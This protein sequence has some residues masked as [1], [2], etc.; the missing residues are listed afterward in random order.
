VIPAVACAVDGA[1]RQDL[2]AVR[3]IRRLSWPARCEVHLDDAEGRSLGLL[4]T[5]LTVRV[6]GDDEPLFTGTVTGANLVREPDGTTRTRLVGQDA[7]HAL[8]GRQTVR[9][10][11]R[12]DPAALVAAVTAGPVRREVDGPTFDRIVQH[13]HDD[14]DLVTETLGR[15]GL[16]VV[17]DGD[18]LRIV[19]LAGYGEPL[20]L[21]HG[22][23]LFQ[24][25]ASTSV[26]RATATE[27]LGWHPQ[28]AEALRGR[29]GDG[30]EPVLLLDE[31]GRDGD[32][33]RAVA[34]GTVDA[35]KAGAVVLD[36]VA[37]GDAR[38]TPGRR[39]LVRG[40][41]EALDTGYTLTAVTSIVDGDGYRSVLS[42]RPP[43]RPAARSATSLTLGTVTAVD[44]PDGCGRVRV[45]LPAYDALDAGWI[46]VVTPGAGAGRGL[47]V[48]PDT[49]DP[50]LVALPHEPTGDAVVL[51]SLFGANRAEDSGTKRWALRTAGGQKIVVDD[52]HDSIRLESRNGG[53]VELA[54]DRLRIHAATDLVIEAPG[55][56]ITVRAATV[57]FERDLGILP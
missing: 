11:E 31:A 32:E 43:Q 45:S 3:V 15:V 25:E 52:E 50:V 19:D 7:L 27:A 55:H 10:F 9:C 42:T 54:P 6:D 47:V 5:P 39:I 21:V 51:G 48:L 17:P 29:A 41:H 38:L 44:D 18:G 46:P 22:D 23:T 4:G 14:L 40:V 8:R 49:G 35:A 56:G 24:V 37:T 1:N 2:L 30:K 12:V 36:A 53:F 57:D 26:P 33:L 13:R 34:R 28:R 16:F 20:P